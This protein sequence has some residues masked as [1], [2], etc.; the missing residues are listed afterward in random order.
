[1]NELESSTAVSPDDKTRSITAIMNQDVHSG[2]EGGSFPRYLIAGKISLI[3]SWYTERHTVH[4]VG[5]HLSSWCGSRP[6]LLLL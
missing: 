4:V 6:C 3:P 5:S 2:G 1:M